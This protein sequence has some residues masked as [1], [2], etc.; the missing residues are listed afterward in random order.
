M[1]PPKTRK[2]V[3]KFIGMVSFYRDMWRKG[4]E[5]LAPMTRLVSKDEK[6]VWTD[7]EQKAFDTIN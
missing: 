2:Q 1:E 4:S 7:V 5:T 6:F 3:R